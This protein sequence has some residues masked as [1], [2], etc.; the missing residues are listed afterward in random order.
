MSSNQIRVRNELLDKLSDVKWQLKYD[1]RL[2]IQNTDVLNALIM[3]HLDKV[4]TEDVLEFR[5][6]YLGKDD[7]VTDI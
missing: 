1:L 7:D 6:E 2:E 4:T 5:R 3:K